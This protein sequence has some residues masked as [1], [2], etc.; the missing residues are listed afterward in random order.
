VESTALASQSTP[1][2]IVETPPTNLPNQ[3]L[4]ALMLY[5]FLLGD[6]ALQ[7]GMPEL[8]AQAYL[9]LA[10]ASR[11][12]RV[13]RRA[14]QIGVEAHTYDRALDALKLWQ[15]LEPL[16]PQAS[17]MQ[18]ALLLGSGR[19]VEATPQLRD[20]LAKPGANQGLI[21]CKRMHF[22]N[23]LKTNTQHSFGCKK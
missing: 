3:P 6:I 14:A 9:E 15:E 20:L 21:L 12:P 23:A 1:Q 16:S 10:K 8:S 2:A 11:D 17:Q 13:A 5:Q 7:R 18:L 19:L 22:C 4:S